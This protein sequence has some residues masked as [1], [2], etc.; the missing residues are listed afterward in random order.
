MPT[1]LI[2]HAR[3]KPRELAARLGARG[4]YAWH[5]DYYAREFMQ[6][7]GHGEYGM[8]RIGLG[9]YNT[10]VEIERLIAALREF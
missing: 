3:L 9:H 5:G 7:M 8:L 4:I 2:T 6:R 1:V 10:A